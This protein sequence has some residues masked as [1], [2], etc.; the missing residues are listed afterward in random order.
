MSNIQK[1]DYIIVGAGITGMIFANE[2]SKKGKVLIIEKNDCVGGVCKDYLAHGIRVNEYGPHIFHT[3]Y[4]EIKKYL[5]QFTQWNKHSLQELYD[6]NG[7]L[8]P[9]PIN[10]VSI[11]KLEIDD[12]D[13]IRQSL[14]KKYNR[15]DK[16]KLKELIESSN[17]YLK[18]LGTFIYDNIYYKDYKKLY[19]VSDEETYELAKNMTAVDISYDCRRYKDKYQAVPSQGYAKMFKRMMTNSNISIILNTNYK[20]LIKID[21]ESASIYY[22]EE[23]FEGHL[24]FT[25][26][27]DEF[28][29]YEYG[30]LPYRSSTF[31]NENINRNFFQNNAVIYRDEKYHFRKIT[32]YKYITGQRNLNTCIQFEYPENYVEEGKNENVALYPIRTENNI[33]LY[34]KYFEES[35]EFPNIT[36]MGRLATYENHPMDMIVKNVLKSVKEI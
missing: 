17:P 16:I 35:H 2:L 9:I 18:Q 14:L 11:G 4:P 23:L 6:M 26:K 33:K 3:K 12:V 19:E 20:E 29:N 31:L 15:N 27:I 34:D 24:I 30:H 22:E 8:L 1:Y 5:S 32:E 25:G 36:F 28:F 13:K 21:Y 10:L 7:T